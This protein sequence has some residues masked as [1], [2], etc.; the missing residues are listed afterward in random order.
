MTKNR[1]DTKLEQV[2]AAGIQKTA[3]VL[4]GEFLGDTYALSKLYD[5]T[6]THEYRKGV[7]S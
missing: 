3:L 4:V 1:I 5:K 7:E 2:K 6:F